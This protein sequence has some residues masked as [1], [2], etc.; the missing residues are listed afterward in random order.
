MKIILD[1]EKCK[2]KIN[3]RELIINLSQSFNVIYY[4]ILDFDT[5][6]DKEYLLYYLIFNHSI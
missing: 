4:Q 2:S 1:T 5:F 3:M 6:Y